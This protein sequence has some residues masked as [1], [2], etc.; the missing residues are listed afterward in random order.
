M[1]LWKVTGEQRRGLPSRAK[2]QV[3]APLKHPG[4]GDLGWSGGKAGS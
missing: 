2:G 3:R 1:A 4:R